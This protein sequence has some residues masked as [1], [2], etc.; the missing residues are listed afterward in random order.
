[1][2]TTRIIDLT[3]DEMRFAAVAGV[4]R[5]IDNYR[6]GRQNRH[7]ESDNGVWQRHI[8]GAMSELAVA[9]YLG[10]GWT[11]HHGRTDQ[12]DL[13]IGSTLVEVRST[14]RPNGRLILHP[15]DKSDAVFVLA[16]GMNGRYKLAGWMLA[17]DAKTPKYWGDK[18][19]N[20]RPAYWIPQGDLYRMK[21]LL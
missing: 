18:A 10:I 14:W 15:E 13:T 12:A 17:S 16:I 4:D 9:K 8:E 11:A 2:S 3:L 6:I 1:M 19:N 20:G 7:G 21:D 5:M